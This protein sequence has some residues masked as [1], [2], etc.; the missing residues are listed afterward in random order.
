[1]E[2]QEYVPGEVITIELTTVN[3]AT[4]AVQPRVMLFQTQM[5]TQNQ[6]QRTLE[7]SLSDEP[8]TVPVVP[9]QHSITQI[10]QVPLSPNLVVSLYSALITVKYFVHISIDIPQHI[11]ELNM[12]LPFVVTTERARA[13]NS[14]IITHQISRNGAHQDRS[15]HSAYCHHQQTHSN[16]NRN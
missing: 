7:T 15:L 3:E 12:N 6:M 9:P 13:N 4:I 10:I 1:M 11:V 8:Y 5:F 14:N 16:V 2:R